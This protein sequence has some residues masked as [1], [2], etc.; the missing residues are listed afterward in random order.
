VFGKQHRLVG[1]KFPKSEIISNAIFIMQYFF[2]TSPS[3]DSS[4]FAVQ[5]LD[6]ERSFVNINEVHNHSV[7]DSSI[8]F[9]KKFNVKLS[10]TRNSL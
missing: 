3:R 7:E 6:D 2:L 8:C 9:F 10:H 5:R 1:S 4:C